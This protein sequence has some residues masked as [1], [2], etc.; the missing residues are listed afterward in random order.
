MNQVA[1]AREKMW[2]KVIEMYRTGMPVGD[3]CKEVKI[4]RAMVYYI[5]RSRDIKLN[6]PSRQGGN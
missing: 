5:L 3:I 6:H 4:T 2:D 1:N